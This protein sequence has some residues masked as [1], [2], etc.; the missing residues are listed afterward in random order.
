MTAAPEAAGG[1]LRQCLADRLDHLEHAER[2]ENEDGIVEICFCDEN[3]GGRAS[4]F[5]DKIVLAAASTFGAEL[6]KEDEVQT[7][8]I[9]IA[10]WSYS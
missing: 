4:M 6:L 7:L 1:L 2:L 3:G 8:C 10:Y 5:V 9:F